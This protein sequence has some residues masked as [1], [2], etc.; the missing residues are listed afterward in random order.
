MIDGS[1]FSV[2][3]IILGAL[4][5]PNHLI[6][7]AGGSSLIG[8]GGNNT[9]QGGAGVDFFIYN[10]GNDIIDNY[11]NGDVIKFDANFTS[12]GISENNF[13]INSDNGAVI[14]RDAVNK[15]IAVEGADNNIVARAYI[16][17]NAGQLDGRGV[18]GLQVIIGG[19]NGGDTIYVDDEGSSIW[20]GAGNFNDKI[21]GSE[22]R[23]EIFYVY[24]NGQDE[25]FNVDSED[26][27]NLFGVNLNQI[28]DAVI[29]ENGVTAKFNDG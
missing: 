17:E 23:D 29:N 20:G 6:A 28:S 27:V 10:G 18:G 14:I 5:L 21:F 7:G 26:V 22:G 11:A 25:L 13:A 8:N 16:S 24:G 2:L 1:A 4:N 15:I 19:S 12:I 9:L 3:E